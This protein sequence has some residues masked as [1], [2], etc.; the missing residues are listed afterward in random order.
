V[1]EIREHRWVA[2]RVLLL[3]A[4]DHLDSILAV[5][6]RVLTRQLGRAPKA[7]VASHIDVRAVTGQRHKVPGVTTVPAGV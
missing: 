5:E 7:R 4:R 1:L 2:S 3:H 6:E